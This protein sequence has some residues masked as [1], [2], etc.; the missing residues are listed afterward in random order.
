MV[1]S[2]M[3]A[4]IINA[5]CATVVTSYHTRGDRGTVASNVGAEE[6]SRSIAT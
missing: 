1:Q 4:L 2:I 5:V 6:M 3:C